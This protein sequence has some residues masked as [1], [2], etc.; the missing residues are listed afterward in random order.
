MKTKLFCSVV[1]IFSL[2]ITLTMFALSTHAK[3]DDV[4]ADVNIVPVKIDI[5]PGTCPN[6]LNVNSKGVLPVAILG[7]LIFDVETIDPDTITLTVDENPEGVSPIRW[8]YEDVATPFDGELCACHDLTGDGIKDLTLEFDTQELVEMLE[9]EDS[10][11][12]IVLTISGES[13]DQTFTFAGMDCVRV[14]EHAR[15]DAK[16]MTLTIPEVYVDGELMYRDV[17]MKQRGNSPN[18]ELIWAE[19]VT[20]EP[21]TDSNNDT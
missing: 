4:I 3:A 16:K 10:E 20:E 1:C 7:T 5:K 14:L 21:T 9:L 17:V 11:E 18:F 6:S 19:P 8:S 12:P 2:L 13:N 15:Y